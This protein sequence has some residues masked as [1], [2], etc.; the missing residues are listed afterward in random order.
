MPCKIEIDD[1]YLYLK[2]DQ[3]ETVDAYRFQSNAKTPEQMIAD[4]AAQYPLDAQQAQAELAAYRQQDALFAKIAREVLGIETLAT[5]NMDAL[6]FQEVSVGSL[7]A[8]LRRAYIA[9]WESTTLQC[10]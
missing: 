7:R 1:E 3:D 5:R 2:D 6:D 10:R 9:G 8:A 4:W